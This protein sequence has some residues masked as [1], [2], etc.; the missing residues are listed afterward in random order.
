MKITE[1]EFL[2][3][4]ALKYFGRYRI[5]GSEVLEMSVQQ[6]REAMEK[7]IQEWRDLI[8]DRKCS[9]GWILEHVINEKDELE[10][11]TFRCANIMCDI[12][13]AGIYFS[14]G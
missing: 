7:L 9:C 11:H 10:R 1:D 6:L 12:H 4:L 14:I 3:E 2:D 8:R 13:K 5:H